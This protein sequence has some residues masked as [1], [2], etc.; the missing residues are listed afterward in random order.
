VVAEAMACGLPAL[1]TDA[2]GAAE[3]VRPGE[4]GWVVPARSSGALASVLE[5]ARSNKRALREMGSSAREA[6]VRRMAKRPVETYASWLS[7]QFGE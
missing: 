6:V 1:V 2:C 4:T 5:R 3:W 7:S